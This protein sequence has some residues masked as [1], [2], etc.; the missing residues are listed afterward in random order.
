MDTTNVYRFSFLFPPIVPVGSSFTVPSG[1]PNKRLLWPCECVCWLHCYR[2][3]WNLRGLTLCRAPSEVI[4]SWDHNLGDWGALGHGWWLGLGSVNVGMCKRSGIETVSI[5]TRV[6]T[7]GP[8]GCRRRVRRLWDYLFG[9]KDPRL[10]P[11]VRTQWKSSICGRP[12][13]PRD[14]P[15]LVRL[16][17]K[18]ILETF[19][20][21]I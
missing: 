4:L 14:P 10:I 11:K 17:I 5:R 9:V 8:R 19:Y 1:V 2:W 18:F 12:H 7:L 15:P 21:T 20:F 13:S 6:K 16:G 3:V